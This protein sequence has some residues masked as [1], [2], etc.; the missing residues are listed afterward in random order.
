MTRRS[1]SFLT[2]LLSVMAAFL[3]SGCQTIVDTDR[4]NKLN[5]TLRYY[6]NSFRW[7]L[8]DEV[9]GY[10]SPE[11]AAETSFPENVENIKIT[12]YEVI[13]PPFFTDELHAA[14][15]VKIEFVFEDQQRVKKIVDDQQWEYRVAQSMW[16]RINPIPPF[17]R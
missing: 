14:Q 6:E 8:L 11:A 10:L 1:D 7:S 9:Y 4:S 12:S 13:R 2:L 17:T 15:T 16:V 5:D 3:V